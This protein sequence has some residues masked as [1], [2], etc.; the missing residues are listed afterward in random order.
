LFDTNNNSSIIS[1]IENYMQI[2]HDVALLFTCVAIIKTWVL[3]A[4]TLSN[5]YVANS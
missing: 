3:S 5:A 4:V 2:I 1:V